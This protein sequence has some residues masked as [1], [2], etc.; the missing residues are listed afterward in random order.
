[1]LHEKSL[2]T[3][4]CTKN[5]RLEQDEL[6]AELE[7]LEELEAAELEDELVAPPSKVP[8]PAMPVPTSSRSEKATREDA[9]ELADL[10]AEMAI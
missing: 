3:W 4:L 8:A 6:E 10:Q 5:R 7:G 2:F 1:M 9:D